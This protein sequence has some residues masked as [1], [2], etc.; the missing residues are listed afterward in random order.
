MHTTQVVKLALALA[1][2]GGNQKNGEDKNKL[3]VRGDPHVLIVGEPGL[4]KSQMLQVQ[5]SL[6]APPFLNFFVHDFVFVVFFSRSRVQT[7][8]YIVA[9]LNASVHALR[10]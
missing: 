10:M 4:G 9:S 7:C 1:L 8:T 5:K 2:F 3:A 6:L